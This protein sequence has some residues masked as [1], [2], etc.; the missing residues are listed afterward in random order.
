MSVW[1]R[2]SSTSLLKPITMVTTA[3]NA[4]TET[5][6]AEFALQ[7]THCRRPSA[8]YRLVIEHYLS[9]SLLWTF[10]FPS[11]LSWQQFCSVQ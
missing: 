8:C 5:Q 7:W 4:K 11:L 6:D 2:D 1:L 10:L 3:M 9:R